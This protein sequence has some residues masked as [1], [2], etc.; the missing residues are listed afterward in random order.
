MINGQIAN[1]PLALRLLQLLELMP[2]VSG[3]LDFAD[4]AFYIT[5][6]RVIFDRLSLEC[7][8]LQLLGEGEM[9]FNT[10]ELD[11]Q[12]RTRG[13]FG[14]LRDL[15]GEI[16][17]R[18]LAIAVTGTLGDP[19]VTIVP[20]PALSSAPKPTTGRWPQDLNRFSQAD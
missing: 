6:D 9:D 17:D 20:L 5:G 18:L 3:S 1:L 11:L 12:F 16:S 13:T 19:K 4:V 8:T 15:V 14:L 7:P 2:P 10:L